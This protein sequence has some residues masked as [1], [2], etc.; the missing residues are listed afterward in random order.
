M[1]NDNIADTIDMDIFI[2]TTRWFDLRTR[3]QAGNA[4]NR[5]FL[6]DRWVYTGG[7]ELTPLAFRELRQ[8]TRGHS[9]ELSVT[10]SF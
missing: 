7:R 5:T 3:L 2:E 6:R 10:G 9:L 8:R 4:F 1:A